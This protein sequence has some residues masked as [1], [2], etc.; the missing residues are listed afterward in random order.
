MEQ[1]IYVV[2]DDDAVRRAVVRLLQSEG[3]EVADFNSAQA[4]L[5]HDFCEKPGCLVLDM[6]MPA[7]DGFDVMDG[8]SRLGRVLPVI[9]LTGFGTIPLTVKAMKTGALEFLTKPVNPVQLLQAVAE[10]LRQ[11]QQNFSHLREQHALTQRHQSLTLRER[12]VLELAIGGLLNKQIATAL[13]VSEITA[14]VHKR[15]VMEKMQARSLADLV[16]SA[17]RLNIVK[18][19]S[20]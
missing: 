3:H 8:L 5:S 1:I 15:R 19:R 18:S 13:G 6:N 20:R 17:E 9:F 10:G 12:E 11:A 14:K 4:F 2:D 7:A 16:R